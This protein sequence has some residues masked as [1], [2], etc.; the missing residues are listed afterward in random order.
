M[1]SQL[2][3]FGTDFTGIRRNSRFDTFCSSMSHNYPYRQP[4]APKDQRANSGSYDTSGPLHSGD[5]N[6]LYDPYQEPPS[7]STITSYQP[8]PSRASTETSSP[9]SSL[10]QSDQTLTLLNS[11]GL[12]PKDLSLLAEIPAG[13]ITVENL[14]HL[15]LGIRKKEA[16]QQPSYL[17]TRPTASYPH[18]VTSRSPATPSPGRAWEQVDQSHSQPL[19]YP[20][21]PQ[22]SPQL[23]NNPLGHHPP[24]PPP[25][26]FPRNQ[27]PL[28]RHGNPMQ[29]ASS[30][31]EPV[32]VRVVDYNYGKETPGNYKSPRSTYSTAHST[33]HAGTSN[34]RKLSISSQT[35]VDY[36]Y[37]LLPAMD[38]RCQNQ[39]VPVVANK[40]AP[41][42]DTPTKTAALDFHGEI[43]QTFPYTC[44]LCDITVLSEKF[45]SSH[46]NGTQH[47]DGQLT[48]LQMYPKWDCR[49]QTAREGDGSSEI[50]RFEEKTGGPSHRSSNYFGKPSSS[51]R[52]NKDPK[53][54]ATKGSGKVVCVKFPTQCLNED[55]LCNFIKQFGEVVKVIM[56]PALAF[57]EMGSSDQAEDLVKYYLGNPAMV[58]GGQ[59]TFSVSSTFNFLQ[60][61]KVLRFSPVP[62]GK[63]SAT[64]KTELLDVAKC[65]GPVEHSLFL[66]TQAF[67]EMTNSVDARK[68][69]EQHTTKPLK[70]DGIH[71][72]VAFSSEYST[73]RTISMRTSLDRMSP[74]TNRESEDQSSRKRTPSP[75][76]RFLS[77]NRD[78]S[79]SPK[80][81]RKS[82]E[83]DTSH[84]KE[85]A[86]S[87]CGAGKSRSRS[88]SER[89]GHRS[90][91]SPSF[92]T[93]DCV[94]GAK[95]PVNTDPEDMAYPCLS[96]TRS[97]PPTNDKTN[98]AVDN[99]NQSKQDT[100]ENSD[101]GFQTCDVDSELEGMEVIGE[102]GDI[103][104]MAVYG[105]DGE[106]NSDMG[107]EEER[108]ETPTKET[109]VDKTEAK[110][111]EEHKE[112]GV[113]EM[114]EAQEEVQK[115]GESK[116]EQKKEDPLQDT[117]KDLPPQVAWHP[118]EGQLE[119][120]AKDIKAIY[121]PEQKATSPSKD[122]APTEELSEQESEREG[123]DQTGDA[124]CC[125][126]EEEPDF[127]EDL[128]NL[129]TLD[130]LEDVSSNDDRD[131]RSTDENKSKNMI[132]GSDEPPRRV[133]YIRNLPRSYY[134]DTDFVK[135]FRGYGK[136][137]RYFLLRSREEGFIEMER[138]YDA[139][140]AIND[141]R[142]NGCK[143]YGQ[144]L[145][146]MLSRKYKRLTT[147]WRPESDS[148][149][150]SDH[151]KECYRSSSR[152]RRERTSSHSKSTAMDEKRKEKGDKK[153]DKN[154]KTKN[155]DEEMD[156]GVTKEKKTEN[157]KTKYSPEKIKERC[158]LSAE[159][160][161][162]SDEE[163]R[164]LSE[165]NTD[166][167]DIPVAEKEKQGCYTKDKL[168]TMP[169][170][171]VKTKPEDKVETEPD[172]MT[173]VESSFEPN[174]PVGREFIKPVVGYFCNLCKLI[175]A[176]EDEAKNQHCSS[177]PHYQKFMELSGKDMVSN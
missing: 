16:T 49:M 163:N 105:E 23:L 161:N 30:R 35:A 79:T 115:E 36:R 6:K 80:R 175:Y 71:I 170:D 116:Q 141:V 5:R 134:T 97:Q 50:Q 118:E 81:R 144:K 14:P 82:R 125:D 70:I 152:R 168:E 155:S 117:P 4:P 37:P 33:S 57:V 77:L 109:N 172:S 145:M 1:R 3:T 56:F 136:V 96:S 106:E 54:S 83:R 64:W 34:N 85:R 160:D 89:H 132:S 146:V 41:S 171:R 31:V 139:A 20:R 43:P 123:G 18:A 44:S 137:H 15:L 47:A 29:Y 63:E 173:S 84:H 67:V 120:N 177:L 9:Y 91:R 11:C 69:V 19:D 129:V 154:T 110:E 143:F 153:T 59:V 38:Y 147:G 122:G 102:D 151:K 78:A 10:G 7:H 52:K 17:G 135:I 150:N 126:D 28:D 149:S 40:M 73:L 55:G 87:G 65:F 95:T 98:K 12:E 176:D 104:G 133:I 121:E 156:S 60:S 90:Y 66:P 103:E 94:S 100:E 39:D 13:L 114:E 42:S 8:S 159:Q 124:S 58:K 45:W 169:E 61:S 86:K 92:H 157:E 166:S 107:E 158:A 48:L 26:P 32:P 93:E 25:Q 112:E 27:G 162:Q 164:G 140:M 128:E 99:I 46:V 76:K 131:N 51:A 21:N 53:A 127:P 174:N 167:R 111:I 142:L 72:K 113:Q 22:R 165:V 75:R 108:P 148:D 138:S 2:T 24:P 74:D 101:G 130:E 62:A 68:F 119:A 88:P